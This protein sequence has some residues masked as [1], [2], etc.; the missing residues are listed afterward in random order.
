MK[1]TQAAI[2]TP[3][4]PGKSE[5][6]IFDE[7]MPGFG[8]R[9]RKGGKRTWIIQFRGAGDGKS[10][11][12][13]LGRVERMRASVAR[14]LA[15]KRLAQA[16]LG[17][18]PNQDKQTARAQ[19]AET[20]KT[21]AARFLT[22]QEQRLKPQSY[23]QVKTH[24]TDHWSTFDKL[25]IHM[26]DRR[27]IAARLGAIAEERGPIAANRARANLSAFFAW[28]MKEG[29]VDVNPVIATN[30][31]ADERARDRVLSDAELVAIWQ[32]CV[33]DDYGRIV[34][35]LI[36]TGQRRDEVGGVRRAEI[37]TKE[38]KWTI[39]GARTKNSNPH[40]VPLSDAAV[41]LF[42]A[43]LA[44]EGR[45]ERA[46]IFGDGKSGA[47]FSGW[48]KAKAAIDARIKKATDEQKPKG[49]KNKTEREPWR[50]HDLR[51]TVATRMADLG[52]QPHIIEA[53]LNHISGHKAGVA[54]FYNRSVYAAEKRQALDLWAAHVEAIVAGNP[55][56]NVVAMKA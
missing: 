5:V 50:L 45:E 33:D 4:P 49:K 7:D 39:P 34:R 19:G 44:R 8:L 43:A 46:A 47:G 54:G 18:N 31:Q 51:R 14:D 10:R 13:T 25:S 26:I 6:R 37:D 22:K 55:A 9:I 2:N 48:S 23:A 17:R 35:L 42:K 16:T 28:A 41:T 11:T 29:L 27:E 30:R 32:A 36:L 40:E 38:R 52:V 56:S 1:L 3:L 21:I 12:H 24:L 53:V 20:F 15:D